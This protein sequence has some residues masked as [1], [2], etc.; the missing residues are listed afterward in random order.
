MIR[1]TN[2]SDFYVG[3]Q[4]QIDVLHYQQCKSDVFGEVTLVGRKY[5]SVLTTGGRVRTVLPTFLF[6]SPRGQQ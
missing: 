4:V 5:V 1:G 3:Q 6:F 2:L